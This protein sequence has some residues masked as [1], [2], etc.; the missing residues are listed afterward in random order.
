MAVSVDLAKLLDREYEEMSLDELIKAPVQA[1]AGVSEGD[2]EM[3]KKAFNI[4]TV[5]DLGRNKFFRA[6]TALVDLTDSK[7]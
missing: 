4:K 5:G 3:L 2:A 1:L 6:A 7:K